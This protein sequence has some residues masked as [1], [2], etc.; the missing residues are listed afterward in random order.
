[1]AARCQIA[2]GGFDI[3]E[4]DPFGDMIVPNLEPVCSIAIPVL[5]PV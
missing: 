1:M 5:G 3:V 2:F 4:I